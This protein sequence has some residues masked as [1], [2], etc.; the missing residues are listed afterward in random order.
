MEKVLD[1]IN[2]F[3]WGVP[4][5]ILIL[6]VG[7]YFSIKT[8]FAQIRL[9]PYA[10]RKFF[11]SLK[12]S[13][14]N[15]S[16]TSAYRALCTA[17]AA[18]VGTGNIAGV[19]G[20]IALGGPGVVFWMWFCAILGM[21]TKFAEVTLAVRY[22]IVTTD[23]KNIGGPMYMIEN[24]LSGRYRFLGYVYCFFCVVAAFGVGNATQINAV[25]SSAQ[26]VAE[27]FHLEIGTLGSLTL[28]SCI[29]VLVIMC[30]WKDN[31]R[32]GR[33]TEK[34]IPFASI[35]YILMCSG[36]LI[37]R[38]D[39][40]ISAFRQIITGAFS[41]RSVTC[42]VIGSMFISLRIGASRGVFTNE[43]GMGTASI[44]HA[45]ADV[46]SPIEQGVMGIVE[47]FLD[48]IVLCTLT[49]LVILCSGV[50]IPYGSDPGILLAMDAFSHI[51]GNWCRL[52]ISV[53]IALFALAT[54]LGWGL[55]GMRCVQFLFGSHAWRVYSIAQAVGILLGSI[56]N[57]SVV[58]TFSEI[59]NGLMAIPN[60][61]ALILLSPE[62]Y[63]ILTDCSTV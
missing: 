35:L 58:W 42:G 14:N 25:T 30:F 55:Y 6:L 23:G 41:P 5:L 39:H 2:S 31:G 46:V 26:A 18:T 13:S 24:G 11:G 63:K 22:R 17:L 51:Y 48:T 28:A 59:V 44:A 56:L 50:D 16:G 8:D 19:A 45:S 47:V 57:T 54:I 60:L 36:V 15:E 62:F 37:L 3:V 10:I 61:I 33:W 29:A 7:I 4:T 49:A 52:L 53:L 12:D 1:T 34:L 27:T 40:I 20:A 43:A 21:I 38:S 9:F 32:I